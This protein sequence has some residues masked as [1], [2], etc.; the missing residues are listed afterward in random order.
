M[1][2][3]ASGLADIFRPQ[4]RCAATNWTAMTAMITGAKFTTK[5]LKLRCAAEPMM[6]LGGSPINVAVPP[7][8]EAN[9]SANK[10]G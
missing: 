7:I 8:F 6:M 2:A 10:N 1:R 3:R 5:S 4:I 9:T